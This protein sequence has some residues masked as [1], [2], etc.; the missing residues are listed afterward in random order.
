MKNIFRIF[1]TDGKNIG[2]NWVA[3]IL[4]GGLILL[5]SLYAWFNIKASWDPYSQTDQI[6]VG[7]VNEDQ[8]AMVR[9]QEI[10]VGDD[11]VDTLQNNNDMDWQFVDRD[12]AMDKVDYGDYFAVIVIPKDFSKKLSTVISDNP[13]KAT[14]EYYVNEKINAIAPKITE[15]GAS[16]IVEQISNNFIA[17]VNGVIFDLFNN[18]GIELESNLPDIKQF[19]EYI[20]TIEKNLPA[21][22]DM[23]NES[24]TDAA[25]AQEIINKAQGLVPKAKQV[26]NNGL[27]TIDSTTE[28]LT[29]AENRLNEM[30]PK[31]ENDLIKIRDMAQSAD[32]FISEIQSKNVDFSQGKD[33]AAQLNERVNEQLK[34]IETI[35]KALRQLQEQ[36]QNNQEPDNTQQ[37]TIDNALKQLGALRNSL[38]KVQENAKLLTA[39]IGEKKQEAD[40]TLADLQQLTQNTHTKIDAFMKEYKETIEPTVLKEV[41][42]AKSTLAN[43]RGILTDIQQTIPEMKHILARTEGNLGEGK[44]KLEAISGEFP[45][46]SNKIN[47]LADRIR[48]IQDETDINE[49]I[50]LLQND[51]E[52]ERSFFAEPVKL[53]ENKLYPIPNYGSGMTPFYTTLAI[54]VG[55]LL[56]IS[57]LS[58]DVVGSEQFSAQQ[59]YYG[60]FLTFMCIGILQTLVV[61]IG[62][63]ALLDVYIHESLWFILF[64]LLIS[65]V[66]M[67]IVYTLV[68]VFGDVGK[69]LAIILLVLQIAGAG[70]TYP[71]ALLPEFFQMIHPF[72]PFTYAIDLMREAVGGIVWDR[73]LKDIVYLMIFGIAA[74]LLGTFLKKPINKKTKL[75]MKK[76]KESGLF[77]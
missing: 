6:P 67:S 16:V 39:F 62:D 27:A 4:I 40:Q 24:L 47:Q 50:E 70:G 45:Y 53:N 69:A 17:T 71:V 54:W 29:S 3:A 46:L 8:G 64:G 10:H 42:K 18:L 12:E 35:E 56:L 38:Q 34:T 22:H 60:R 65:I 52:A 75:L 30:A 57:L 13:K 61:T 2:T 63:I 14:V 73:A 68:S 32:K 26:T 33:I 9:D 36:N 31:I 59:I 74:L 25:N 55:A 49:I 28:F 20:F 72:L 43:A 19:E 48:D 77:H 76:S 41:A 11:L 23:L 7:V 37:P 5:P 51:P 1:K 44:E 15:K 58:V 21:I 66:F